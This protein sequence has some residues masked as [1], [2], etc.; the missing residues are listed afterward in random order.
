MNT[1]RRRRL[2]VRVRIRRH[3]AA[4][5]NRMR[6]SL[7][8]RV[9]T[10]TALSLALALAGMGWYVAAT[11]RDGL[12]TE[13]V[14][15]MLGDAAWRIGQ[16]QTQLDQATAATQEQ[17][18]GTAYEVVWRLQEPGS[19]IVGAM[20][21]RSPDTEST[22]EILEP[23]SNAALR[24]LP[25]EELRANVSATSGLHW[26]SVEIPTPD[27]GV[28][29]VV[30]GSEVS[31]PL[32][33]S[34]ELYLVYTL[35][36]EQENINLTM[37]ALGAGALLLVIIV[38]LIILVIMWRVLRPVRAAALSA[39]RLAAG[40]LDVQMPVR[41]EDELATLAR[42]FNEMAAA[43][44]TQIT[45]LED[46]SRLQ[47]RFVSDVSH[48]LRTPLT[49]IRMAADLI[50]SRVD[51][52][53]PAMRRSV[54][55]LVNQLDRFES[56][57]ADLLEISRIDAGSASISPETQDLRTLV[58]RVVELAEPL[59]EQVG[60]RI[61]VHG[62]EHAI[63]A[64]LDDI[65]VERIVRNL[66]V[67][68]VEHSNGTP[69]DV[70]L[71]QN[72]SAVAVRVTDRGVGIS[73]E[74]AARVFDRFWR[75]DPARARTTGGPGLGLA[76]AMEDARAHG[77]TLEAWGEEGVVASFLLTLP[78]REGGDYTPPLDVVPPSLAALAVREES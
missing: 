68:A 52:S 33:G 42:S 76:I 10:I 77:G 8:L 73:L 22:T 9:S 20:L 30:I 31:V 6:R 25:T 35:A 66:V 19:G 58:R 46:L 43:L 12:F 60:T 40:V 21:L 7:S 75:A 59:A 34:H 67:N 15:Q 63:T 55:L 64:D 41:G 24:V 17:V 53:D 61:R 44:R 36:P 48:E 78:R 26:Q 57:L 2:P 1:E 49:T 47:Q 54:E 62:D 74:T 51:S 65:R 14:G 29:G 50:D 37:R 69:V 39:E 71:G 38:A 27:G 23:I 4:I 72:D 3:L 18:Q 13:R 56:M 70:W 28:P 32:A 11:I 16:A 45:Q 5:A